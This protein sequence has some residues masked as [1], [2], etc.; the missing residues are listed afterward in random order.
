MAS[1]EIFPAAASRSMRGENQRG[2]EALIE[3]PDA[4]VFG[5]FFRIG[6]PQIRNRRPDHYDLTFFLRGGKQLLPFSAG[7]GSGQSSMVS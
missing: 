4:G 2:A 6:L 3:Q 1:A 7:G 5:K